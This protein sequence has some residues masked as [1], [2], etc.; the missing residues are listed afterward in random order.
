MVRQAL[1]E[2][3][4]GELLPRVLARQLT[5]WSE[6]RA[7]VNFI[8]LSEVGNLTRS[9]ICCQVTALAVLSPTET[10]EAVVYVHL[11]KQPRCQGSDGYLVQLDT[12]GVA[13]THSQGRSVDTN[14]A[15]EAGY[16]CQ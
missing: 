11:A 4:G 10:V 14:V 6:S 1:E 8:L 16:R 3:N 5:S 7:T 15:N 9:V 13:V 2:M 12:V